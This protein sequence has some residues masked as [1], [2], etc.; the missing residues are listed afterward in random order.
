MKEKKTPQEQTQL[1]SESS[2][3]FPPL[4]SVWGTH[5]DCFALTEK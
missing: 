3:S 1:A 4:L 5:Y 2:V